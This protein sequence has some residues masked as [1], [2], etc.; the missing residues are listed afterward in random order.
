MGSLVKLIRWFW[1]GW[2]EGSYQPVLTLCPQSENISA[3][4]SHDTTRVK[5]SMM[6][7]PAYRWKLRCRSVGLTAL[8]L[9]CSLALHWSVP[10]GARANNFGDCVSFCLSQ[11]FNAF[12]VG[13]TSLMTPL[14][15]AFS[16]CGVLTRAAGKQARLYHSMDVLESQLYKF[17][18]NALSIGFLEEHVL[19]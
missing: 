13:F 4:H 3:L 8:L 12:S 7:T 9:S 17:W 14:S 2:E 19:H 18:C 16:F 1:I 15:L 6:V 11:V 5:K 10:A